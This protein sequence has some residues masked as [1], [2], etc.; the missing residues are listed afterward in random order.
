MKTQES[1][2]KVFDWI[3]FADTLKW[4]LVIIIGLLIFRKPI[5]DLINRITKVGYG[6]KSLEAKQQATANEKKTEEISNIDRLVGL[7]RKETFET[8][9]EAIIRESEVNTLNT[10]EE[11][12]ERLM[13]YGCLLYIMRHFD[14]IYTN[15]FGSQIRILEHVNSHSNQTRESIKFFFDNAEKNNPK[16]YDSYSYE[17][18]LSFLFDFTLLRED[19]GVLNITILGVDFLKYLTESNKDV[20]IGN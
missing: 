8:F 20:N 5:I 14:I 12:I 11:K 15:I 10:T 18:Y 1:I 9:R 17:E 19:N 16:F 2:D 6:N 3:Q 7:F 13:K 4:P